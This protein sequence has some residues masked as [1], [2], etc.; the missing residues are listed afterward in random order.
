MFSSSGSVG[1]D[2]ARTAPCGDRRTNEKALDTRQAQRESIVPPPGF[3]SAS[4][5]LGGPI[6]SPTADTG[7]LG[8][9]GGPTGAR[10]RA[11]GDRN[12]PDVGRPAT[13]QRCWVDV[14]IVDPSADMD[15]CAGPTNRLAP[16]DDLTRADS[17][18]HE[19][20]DRDSDAVGTLDHNEPITAHS[21][22][23]AHPA[24]GRGNDDRS[25]RRADVD[26]AISRPIGT[27]G[28]TPRV[29][30]RPSHRCRA[31]HGDRWI[32]GRRACRRRGHGCRRGRGR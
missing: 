15:R 31:L 2:L 30:N 10:S 11:S 16:T 1:F 4:D 21:T 8:G 7:G 5:H 32:G 3:R 12:Q 27:G 17:D 23:K 20:S 28:R 14:V 26:A 6:V 18:L 29:D 24:V 9:T 13:E 19:E 22:G 25:R